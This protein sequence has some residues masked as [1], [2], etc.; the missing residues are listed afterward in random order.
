MFNRNGSAERLKKLPR[1]GVDE[2]L[3]VKCE[4]ILILLS[5]NWKLEVDVLRLIKKKV[6]EN[7]IDGDFLW[8]FDGQKLSEEFQFENTINES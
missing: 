3:A 1:D 7:E 5:F 4:G 8:L 6:S 2:C